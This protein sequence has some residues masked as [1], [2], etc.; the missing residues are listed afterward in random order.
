MI[1]YYAKEKTMRLLTFTADMQRPVISFFDKC[2]AA[3]GWVY[4]PQGRH[5][6][7]AEI[8]KYYMHNGRFRCLF[9]GNIL[10]GTVGLHAIDEKNKIYELKR[11]FVLP[12]YQKKGCG[13]LLLQCAIKYAKEQKYNSICLM[14]AGSLQ[15]HSAS[16]SKMG[17]SR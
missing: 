2:F 9:D 4:E 8:G 14:P 7:T 16:I 17:L 3:L 15:R 13:N 1:A 12:E 6:D 10:T 11:L 5:I